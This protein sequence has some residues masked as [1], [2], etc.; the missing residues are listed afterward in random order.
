MKY[1]RKQYTFEHMLNLIG[2]ASK[3]AKEKF[4]AEFDS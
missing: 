1:S 2:K 4:L 3:E